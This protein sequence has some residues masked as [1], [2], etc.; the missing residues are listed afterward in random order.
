M[1]KDLISASASPQSNHLRLN[2]S[3]FDLLLSSLEG[4]LVGLLGARPAVVD[5]F[6]ICILICMKRFAQTN[7]DN[8]N[9]NYIII[10]QICDLSEY[11]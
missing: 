7:G 4:I 3:K 9:V 8:N 10:Y 2:S 1:V 6:I 11:H 5:Q